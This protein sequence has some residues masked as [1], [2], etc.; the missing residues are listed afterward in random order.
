MAR[1]LLCPRWTTNAEVAWNLADRYYEPLNQDAAFRDSLRALFDRLASLA[2]DEDAGSPEWWQDVR[3]ADTELI[4]LV[5]GTARETFYRRPRE[6]RAAIEDFIARWP[7]PGRVWDDLQWSFGLWAAGRDRPPRL[8]VGVL[9]D[10]LPTPSVSVVLAE[11]PPAGDRPGITITTREPR[12]VLN[13]LLPT[14]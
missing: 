9:A 10:W 14:P 13:L 11:I 8:Q 4:A 7:L 5:A 3:A 12:I 1:A 2:P 6:A